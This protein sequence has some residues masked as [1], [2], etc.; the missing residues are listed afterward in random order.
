MGWTQ[1]Q[2]PTEV[3]RRGQAAANT[4]GSPIER[5]K[6]LEIVSAGRRAQETN[7]APADAT[8]VGAG[9]SGAEPASTRRCSTHAYDHLLSDRWKAL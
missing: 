8:G 2:M 7:V 9:L 6:N 3:E 1:R 5:R 4:G